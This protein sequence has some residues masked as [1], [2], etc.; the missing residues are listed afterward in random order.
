MY[1]YEDIFLWEIT[2]QFTN[3]IRKKNYKFFSVKPDMLL[4]CIE[5]LTL[6]FIWC[7]Y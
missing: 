3:E 2:I 7:S 6:L 5:Y 1:I 4:K